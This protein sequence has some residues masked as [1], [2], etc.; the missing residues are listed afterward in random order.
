MKTVEETMNKE[1]PT[2]PGDKD[3]LI[4]SKEEVRPEVTGETVAVSITLPVRPK[5]VRV[6]EELLDPPDWKLMLLGRGCRR[7]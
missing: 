3:T 6:I 2:E 1:V 5:P 7:L 4:G